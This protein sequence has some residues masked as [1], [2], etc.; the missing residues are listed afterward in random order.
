M[1]FTFWSLSFSYIFVG[2]ND[3]MVVACRKVYFVQEEWGIAESYFTSLLCG[4]ESLV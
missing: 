2:E 3:V 1:H 4:I